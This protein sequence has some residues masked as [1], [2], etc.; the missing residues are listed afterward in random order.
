MSKRKKSHR[1]RA[2]AQ[3]GPQGYDFGVWI[4]SAVVASPDFLDLL[5]KSDIV[6]CAYGRNYSGKLGAAVPLISLVGTNEGEIRKVCEEF[7]RWGADTNGDVIELTMGFLPTGYIVSIGRSREEA[8]ARLTGFDRTSEPL[9]FGAWWQKR[10]DTRHPVLQQIR[11]YKQ[12]LISPVLVSFLLH[13]GPRNPQNA[14]F[15]GVKPISA[16]P[17]FVK[18]DLE[19][20]DVGGTED[21]GIFSSQLSSRKSRVLRDRKELRKERKRQ[22]TEPSLYSSRRTSTLERHFPVTLERLRRGAETD[23]N[24]ASR[25]GKD[26]VRAWQLQQAVCNLVLSRQICKGS[27]Y[28]STVSSAD[29]QDVILNAIRGRFEIADGSNDVDQISAEQVIEQVRLDASYLLKQLDALPLQ[30]DLSYL[31]QQLAKMHFLD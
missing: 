2:Q 25:L 13:E 28:Y 17:D 22:A 30:T 11:E 21:T 20:V 16:L 19:F 26:G 9:L 15:S 31:Q 18:F 10:I 4:N 14:D 8:V 3:V 7:R 24:L 29:I 27:L 12:N 6:G 5:S 23:N 1:Q